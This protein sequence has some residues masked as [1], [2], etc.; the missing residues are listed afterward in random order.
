[1]SEDLSH[2][3]IQDSMTGMTYKTNIYQVSSPIH[4]LLN[5]SSL[6]SLFL[7]QDDLLLNFDLMGM[8]NV[9]ICPGWR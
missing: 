8:E 9:S 3:Y 6:K 4:G 2:V 1:M 5:I 7:P